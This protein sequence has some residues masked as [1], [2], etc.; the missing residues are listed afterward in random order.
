MAD[1]TTAALIA[2][3]DVK[4][5]Q[6]ASN[7]RKAM[8]VFDNGGR[9]I[10][11]RAKQIQKNVQDSFARLGD[12]IVGGAAL[13]GIEKFVTGI[14]DAGSKI[15]D[16]SDALG[17]GTDELQAWGLLAGRAGVGQD[18]FNA[19][20]EKLGKNLGNASIKGGDAAKFYQ[21]LGIDLHGG[22]TAGFY[23]LA[24][25]VQKTTDPT[26]KASIVTTALGKSA[27]NLVPILSQGSAALKAQVAAFAASGQ[28]IQASAI[29]KIDDLGDAWE[30]LKR[31]FQAA[32]ANALAEPLQNLTDELKDP[33][34]QEGLK[35]FAGLL[36]DIAVQMAK[37]A[38]YAPA[39]A[40]AYAGFRLGKLAG[41]PGAIAGAAVGGIVGD[42]LS[43]P[44]AGHEQ[45]GLSQLEKL[46]RQAQGL[47]SV[48]S[49]RPLMETFFGDS[50]A[51]KTARAELSGVETQ[52]KSIQKAAAPTGKPAPKGAGG[53]RSD[54]T[55]A[56]ALKRLEGANQIAD[57]NTRDIAQ[58]SQATLRANAD[59]RSDN[60]DALDSTI[61]ATKA[62]F[63][64]IMTI[65]QGTAQFFD[66]QKQAI[67]AL[68]ELDIDSTNERKANALKSIEETSKAEDKSLADERASRVR[69]LDEM[70][71]QEK[72]TRAQA[73]QAL[74]A[75]DA[76]QGQRRTAQHA[77]D[78]SRITTLEQTTADKLRAINDKKNADL[79]QADQEA[80][81]RKIELQQAA[82]QALSN[83]GA[84]NP[85]GASGRSQQAGAQKAAEADAEAQ[86]KAIDDALKAGT[87]SAQEAA[88]A[89]VAI[90]Q[91]ANQKILDS[92]TNLASAQLQLGQ[93]TFGKLA[94][95]VGDLVGKSSA[96][97]KALFAVSK[98][99]AI[100]DS[101][102]KIQQGVA[103]ALTLPFP[104]NIPAI[105][106][107]AAAGAS[108]LSNIAAV[109]GSFEKGGYTGPGGR[110]EPAGTVHKGEVVFSQDDVRRFGGPGAVDAMR[111]RGY[112]MGGIVGTVPTVPTVHGPG[113]GGLKITIK[114]QPGVAVEQVGVSRDEVVF[115]ARRILHAEGPG[116]IANNTRNPNGEVAKANR[117]TIKA[118]RRRQ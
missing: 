11:K 71:Q 103:A 4:F 18:A 47:K 110:Y 3:L 118:P 68:A 85:F 49:G 55:G 86:N 79:Y 53:D 74:T 78:A 113:T 112:S 102:V 50:S 111:R 43:K 14:V 80:L 46:Q 84:S 117:A 54:L 6:L 59:I 39:L 22:V 28:I 72:I 21:K 91:D 70:V 44:R 114:Q 82:A 51:T 83:A 77:A 92:F 99:F 75:L 35:T 107:V 45:D 87:I 69:Q 89:R 13:V 106:S 40:G 60:Q 36:A 101:I 16:T 76:T 26:Q 8:T 97:Y 64:A 67:E 95:G 41:V 34:V 2:S 98:A 108:I 1:D 65:Q 81:Q 42:A 48:I 30:D 19:S 90:E 29:D 33:A 57:Q 63:D 5:D 93:D 25:A 62:H 9:N 94:D 38:K 20:L 37:A 17:V 96:A 56:D 115:E 7:M 23:E 12:A 15:K 32:G 66:L 31:R 27:G 61:D 104:A 105:A 88:D 10:E 58:T 109:S 24:D 73:D 116:V 52:I 100:A